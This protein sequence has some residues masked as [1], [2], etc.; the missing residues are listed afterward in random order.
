MPTDIVLVRDKI[1]HLLNTSIVALTVV[2][3]FAVISSIFR[4][5]DIGWQPAM[6]VH[7]LLLTFLIGVAFFRR[8]IP[9]FRKSVLVLGLFYLAGLVGSISFGLIGNGI[10][11]LA[12]FVMTSVALLGIRAGIIAVILSLLT[13]VIT[14]ALAVNNHLPINIDHTNYATNATSWLTALVVFGLISGVTILVIGRMYKVFTESL[15]IVA[16]QKETLEQ[17]LS[18]IKMLEGII[19]ICAYCHSIRNDG[20]AWDQLENY[21][22][23]H[24]DATF[25]HGVCPSCINKARA[26]FGLEAK[27]KS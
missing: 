7:L 14:G 8:S 13:I 1:D 19:P 15:Q 4:A 2:T 20:G 6:Y 11:L 23:N 12:G 17:T 16:R 3:L 26:D 25:S 24:S 10:L 27:E 22:A 21:I 18:Q 9:Y 5:T